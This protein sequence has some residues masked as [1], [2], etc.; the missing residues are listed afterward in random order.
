MVTFFLNVQQDDMEMASGI[1]EK[2][3]ILLIIIL[4]TDASCKYFVFGLMYQQSL[5]IYYHADIFHDHIN[6]YFH[7]P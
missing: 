2:D 7:I 5:Y 4:S 1:S 6:I 3:H